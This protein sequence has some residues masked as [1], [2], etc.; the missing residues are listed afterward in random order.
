MVWFVSYFFIIL[1]AIDT[2]Y[3]KLNIN[4]Q[5]A[6]FVFSGFVLILLYFSL[7]LKILPDVEVY[8]K[9]YED[10]QFLNLSDEH[11]EQG[12][13]FFTKIF[14]FLGFNFYAFRIICIFISTVLFFRGIFKLSKNISISL[15]YFYVFV[16]SISF[17]VQIRVGMGLAIYVGLGL[18]AYKQ[19]KT[20][21]SIFSIALACLFHTSMI[22]LIVPYFLNFIKTAKSKFLVLI[23]ALVFMK[24]NF[25]DIMLYLAQPF[26][27]GKLQSY[28]YVVGSP[29]LSS[30]DYLTILLCVICAFKSNQNKFDNLMYWNLF[31]SLVFHYIFSPFGEIS[32][33]FY[34][35]YSYSLVFLMPLIYK[36]KRP[37]NNFCIYIFGFLNLYLLISKYGNGFIIGAANW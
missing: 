34:L 11:Y 29:Y 15:L 23:I 5:R 17:L 33:R 4:L 10:Y 16:F 2:R 28:M 35:L 24:L 9:S 37:I 13:N 36:F 30:R 18:P 14:T 32:V 8:K 6:L 12:Y 25:I 31:C 19:G 1:F 27:G 3:K 20:F 7:N 26:L 22:M 21:K